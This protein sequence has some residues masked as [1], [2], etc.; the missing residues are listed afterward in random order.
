MD[1]A[2]ESQDVNQAG[3]YLRLAYPVCACARCGAAIPG[4]P[5]DFRFCDDCNSEIDDE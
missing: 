1:D 5:S 4:S 2:T 3:R